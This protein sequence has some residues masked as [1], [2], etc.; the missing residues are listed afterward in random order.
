MRVR[1]RRSVVLRNL[2]L[3]EWHVWCGWESYFMACGEVTLRYKL[4]KTGTA[5]AQS[6]MKVCKG[7][8]FDEG[9]SKTQTGDPLQPT[10][11]TLNNWKFPAREQHPFAAMKKIEGVL[12]LVH[13][14][15]N[16]GLHTE[17][18]CGAGGCCCNMCG[19]TCNAT[20]RG[21][22]HGMDDAS[23]IS[24]EA[25]CTRLSLIRV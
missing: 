4:S 2:L 16:L 6:T 12:G 19:N 11:S 1:L 9:R 7:I 18:M 10:Q 13:W 8:R 21:C 25:L 24:T 15:W 23:S 20:W 17:N 5:Q 22:S 3:V 14:M